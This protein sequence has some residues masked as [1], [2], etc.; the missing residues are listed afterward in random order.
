MCNSSV[1]FM[2][3]GFVIVCRFVCN[4]WFCGYFGVVIGGLF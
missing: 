3:R 4:C 1:R 2:C